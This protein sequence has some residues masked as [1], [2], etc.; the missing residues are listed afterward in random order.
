MISSAVALSFSLTAFNSAIADSIWDLSSALTLSPSSFNVFSVWY[1][2]E[3]AW[4]NASILS[5]FCLSAS[6]FISA[7]FTFLSI[8]SSLKLVPE[9]IVTFCSFPVP[10]SLAVTWTIPLASIS[11]V[12]SIWG[13]PLGAGG[14]SVNWNL[15]KVVLS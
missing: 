12:T 1:I 7:S 2:V 5:F 3:S 15:P 4:F 10:K 13:I 14:I 6:A 8:S 9:V 11:K